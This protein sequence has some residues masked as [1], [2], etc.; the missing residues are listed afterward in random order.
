MK[1]GVEADEGGGIRENQRVREID[2][3]E[4]R[5]HEKRAKGEEGEVESGK[6]GDEKELRGSGMENDRDGKE[7][8]KEKGSKRGGTGEGECREKNKGSGKEDRDEGKTGKKRNILIRGME[9]RKGRRKKMA[10]KTMERIGAK[11]SIEVVRRIGGG[12]EK[13]KETV[14]V[15]L[16]NEEQRRE[17]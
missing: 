8:K 6:G 10:E 13:D 7:G 11:V 9:V 14:L 16:G 5:E 12:R 17:V 2:E 4:N 1:G 3:R 15:R